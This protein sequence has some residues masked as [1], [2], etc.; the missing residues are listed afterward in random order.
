LE[1]SR[2]NRGLRLVVS[3]FLWSTVNTQESRGD[4]LNQGVAFYKRRDEWRYSLIDALAP[5]TNQIHLAD[6]VQILQTIRRKNDFGRGSEVT[7]TPTE[8]TRLLYGMGYTR[9]INGLLI[10]GL[11]Y[12]G[13]PTRLQFPFVS[14]I[15]APEI[16]LKADDFTEDLWKTVLESVQRA[17]SNNRLAR[18]DWLTDPLPSIE[19][20]GPFEGYELWTKINLARPNLSVPLLGRGRAALKKYTRRRYL[21]HGSMDPNIA[22][23]EPRIPRGV[24]HSPDGSA[25]FF[26]TGYVFATR[27]LDVAIFAAT[28]YGRGQAGWYTAFNRSEA[29]T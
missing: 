15:L 27:L 29:K 16:S 5:A 9:A 28:V 6:T 10:S 18:R 8:V 20:S 4:A 14:A 23:F 7:L 26:K 19:P 13:D 11:T 17:R 24:A 22:V 21:L 1:R 2:T 3:K 25:I 12:L